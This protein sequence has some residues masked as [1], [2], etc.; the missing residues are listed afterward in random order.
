MNTFIFELSKYN[1]AKE[2]ITQS[3][4]ITNIKQHKTHMTV[5]FSTIH[6]LS[7]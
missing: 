1:I 3:I 6:N 4:P 7:L 5:Y 2:S